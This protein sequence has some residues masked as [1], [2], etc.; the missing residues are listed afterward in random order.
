MPP[1]LI[2]APLAPI[3]LPAPVPSSAHGRPLKRN[4]SGE[5]EERTPRP[6]E[7]WRFLTPTKTL[8]LAASLAVGAET[9]QPPLTGGSSKKLKIGTPRRLREETKLIGPWRMGEVVGNGSTGKVRL[10]RHTIDGS[11]AAVKKVPK[12]PKDQKTKWRHIEREIITMKLAEHPRIVR[13]LDIYE[14]PTHLYLINELCPY[15]ELYHYLMCNK[16]SASVT[17]YFFSQLVAALQHLHL[18]SIA[19]RDIKPE[20]LLLVKGPGGALEIKLADLGMACFQYPGTFLSTSCG[21][22]HYAAPEIIIGVDYDGLAADIW[23]TGVVLFA[24]TTGRLPFDDDHIPTLLKKIKKGSFSFPT[25]M[26]KDAKDLVSKMMLV[27]PQERIGIEEVANHPYL[28]GFRASEKET[29]LLPYPLDVDPEQAQ[30]PTSPDDLDKSIM[31][32]LKVVLP[33]K[34]ESDLVDAVLHEAL[35]DLPQ[36]G[37]FGDADKI[38]LIYFYLNRSI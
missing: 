13:L 25:S 28:R 5:Q 31:A 8:A 22:P 20:N 12:P 36:L 10:V 33:T 35:V 6:D 26:D 16:L 11:F 27:E 2:P 19:H 29:V 38:E 4:H 3:L 30:P 7:W 1:T 37:V 15:G 32:S 34:K 9:R 21:S 18:L 23:S 24:L 14:T 17:K